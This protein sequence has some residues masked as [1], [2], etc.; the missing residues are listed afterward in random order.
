MELMH[1]QNWLDETLGNEF[2]NIL[3]AVESDFD[4]TGNISEIEYKSRDGFF[5]F[6]N[7]GLEFMA[8]MRLEDVASAATFPNN[9]AVSKELERAIN[10]GYEQA[11]ELFIEN[12]REALSELFTTEQLDN[13]S[14]DI[15][16]HTLYSLHQ[17][18]LAESLSEYEMENNQETFFIQHRVMF[19]SADN[20]RNITGEDEIY[21]YSGV[22]TDYDYGRDKGLMDCFETTVKVGDLTPNKVKDIVKQML[23]S[24]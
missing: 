12:N 1:T 17:G 8:T 9:E 4:T 24:I 7:G 13:K 15:N 2:Q 14:D 18:E 3:E 23:H 19:F 21:F 5:P 16:Y 20:H 10:Y 22:N 6:T 11:R